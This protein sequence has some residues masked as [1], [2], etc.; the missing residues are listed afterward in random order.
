RI[1]SQVSAGKVPTQPMMDG[2][3]A[4]F[5]AALLMTPGFVTDIIGILLLLPPTR[6]LIRPFLTRYFVERGRR[7]Q[8]SV[9]FGPG[10]QT[11][12]FM[13]RTGSTGGTG[14][15]AGRRSDDDIIDVD[16]EPEINRELE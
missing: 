3:L 13:W 12:T 1:Q 14:R 11:R 10:F 16:P 4:L 5:A 8:S 2:F 6:A 7:I 15:G 9:G